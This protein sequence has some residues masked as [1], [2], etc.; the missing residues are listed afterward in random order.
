MTGAFIQATVEPE[1]VIDAMN[2]DPQFLLEMWQLMAERLHM[3]LL[4]DNT[5]DVIRTTPGDDAKRI[6][7]QFKY[8]ASL[9][10]DDLNNRMETS[11]VDD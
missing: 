6:S 3:G 2:E 9:I 1:A 10:D 8:L 11:D 4:L 7:E 5:M